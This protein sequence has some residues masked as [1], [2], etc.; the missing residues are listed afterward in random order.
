MRFI[1]GTLLLI[2]GLQWLRKAILRAA[3]LKAL[4]DEEEAFMEEREAALRAGHEQR[5]GLD[6]FAFVV[7][8]KAVLLEG[9]E[10]VFI[11]LTFG[12]NALER[13]KAALGAKPAPADVLSLAAN[14]K[15]LA[16][17]LDALE[18]ENPFGANDKPLSLVGMNR[19]IDGNTVR[20]RINL[21]LKLFAF[22]LPQD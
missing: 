7:S 14:P 4:H 16:P 5:L 9:L 1:F 17:L 21:N 13:M 8:F 10:V 19:V 11:V 22:L 6:W 18:I 15:K 12:V 20:V 2:F 3:G